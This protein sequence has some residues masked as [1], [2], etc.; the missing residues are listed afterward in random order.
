MTITDKRIFEL[1]ARLLDM[2]GDK[3]GNHGCNMRSITEMPQRL[4]TY[5]ACPRVT[6][7]SSISPTSA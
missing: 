6:A 7:S 1:A 4:R 5:G 2:A 3:F